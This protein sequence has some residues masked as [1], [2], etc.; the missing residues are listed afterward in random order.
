MTVYVDAAIWRFAGR[1]WCHL[2]ADDQA[3]LHRFAARLG[4]HPSSYQGPPKTSAPH[5]DIT[6]FER[7]RALRMGAKAS[8]RDEIVAVFRRVRTVSMRKPPA[9]ERAPQ[10]I[11]ANPVPSEAG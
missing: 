9:Q 6:A 3:E 11:E 4:I 1:K 7:D 2:M 10:A 8:S 5:Y